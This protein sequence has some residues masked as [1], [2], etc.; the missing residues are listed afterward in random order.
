[1]SLISMCSTTWSF[2]LSRRGEC[3]KFIGI[4]RETWAKFSIEETSLSESE[5]S[6]SLLSLSGGKL[7]VFVEKSSNSKG[8]SSVSSVNLGEGELYENEF[9]ANGV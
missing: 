4:E 8:R 1:M 6:D 2:T 7:V 5:L 3:E 9:A